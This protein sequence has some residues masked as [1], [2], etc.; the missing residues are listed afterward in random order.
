MRRDSFAEFTKA[1]RTDLAEPTQ[2]EID[3]LVEYL[4][5][6]L[7]EAEITSLVE[8]AIKDTGASS[9]KDMGKVMGIVNPQVKGRADGK[10]VS[11]IVK[12]LLN[13]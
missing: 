2:R 4:P 5:A 6:Q 9:P 12:K 13:S 3:I 1:G 10:Q 7:T 11:D 8:Q